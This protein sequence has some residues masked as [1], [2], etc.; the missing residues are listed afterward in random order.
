MKKYINQGFTLIELMI[1]IA[2][3]G[4]LAA[5]AMP[6]YQ[7]YVARAQAMEGFS[8]TSGLRNDI[9]IWVYENKAYPDAQTVSDSG[10][11]GQQATSLKGKY[12][13]KVTVAAGTGDILI[14]FSNGSNKGKVLVISPS[15]NEA[16]HTQLIKWTCGQT[17]KGNT[18]ESNRMPSSCREQN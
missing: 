12:I 16:N 18:L 3:I 10:Y 2:I 17:N 15:I 6:A 13:G 5:I 1:V 14:P 7:N 8:V 11:I 9:A 4:I